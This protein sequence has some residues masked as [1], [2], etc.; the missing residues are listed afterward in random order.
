MF[1]I[2]V[3]SG[4]KIVNFHLLGLIYYLQ[5]KFDQYW[6]NEDDPTGPV[7]IQNNHE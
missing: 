2:Y 3:I 4:A 6:P 5:M 7:S 1:I